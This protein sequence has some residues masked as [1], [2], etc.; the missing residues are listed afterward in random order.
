MIMSGGHSRVYPSAALFARCVDAD[1]RAVGELV[2]TVIEIVDRPGIVDDVALG[3]EIVENEPRDLARVGTSMSA[4]TTTS[5]RVSIIMCPR[6]H[7][8]FMT[9]FACPGYD[10][11]IE[12]IAR[13]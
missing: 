9:F 10:L 11:R 5:T 6:P 1:L 8:A 13:L 2:R 4:S 3:R 12:T 7:S